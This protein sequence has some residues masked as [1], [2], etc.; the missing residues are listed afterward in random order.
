M[1]LPNGYGGVVKLP[2]KR[3]KPW[4]VRISVLEEGSDGIQHRKRKYLEYF[5]TQKEAL[6]Y[7]ADYNKG[8]AV[9]EHTSISD[10]LTFK[11]LFDKWIKWR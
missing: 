9:H 8:L 7:L 10:M 1:K 3:R 4:G 2:G 6:A 5:A 11:E